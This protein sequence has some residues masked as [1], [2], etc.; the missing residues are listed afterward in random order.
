MKAGH[1]DGVGPQCAL[2]YFNG[3]CIGVAWDLHT[4]DHLA[5]GHDAPGSVALG[6]AAA[7]AGWDAQLDGDVAGS[8]II[9]REQTVEGCAVDAAQAAKAEGNGGGTKPRE[10]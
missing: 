3:S 7:S 5:G 9:A 10:L 8:F 4:A 6:V 2:H 1:R